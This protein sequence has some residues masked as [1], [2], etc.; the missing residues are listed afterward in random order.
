MNIT[1]NF[2]CWHTRMHH[3]ASRFNL[4]RSFDVSSYGFTV[5]R[6]SISYRTTSSECR[7]THLHLVHGTI[8]H[9]SACLNT[10]QPAT[11]SGLRLVN[12][13]S[14]CLH[15]TDRSP[16]P[17]SRLIQPPPPHPLRATLKVLNL[18]VGCVLHTVRA[19]MI[20]TGI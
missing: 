2:A 9:R 13:R 7:L 4:S 17:L 10:M 11:H 12:S 6:F 19:Y 1:L 20:L 16:C 3:N 14:Q 8:N 18:R 5:R 15:F